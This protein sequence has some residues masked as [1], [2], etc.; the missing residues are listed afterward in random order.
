MNDIAFALL[1][2]GALGTFAPNISAK[3]A[4][5]TPPKASHHC[6]RA[7]QL[8]FSCRISSGITAS[9]CASKDLSRIRGVLTYRIGKPGQV[10]LVYPRTKRHPYQA[11]RLSVFTR[12]YQ[13]KD[14]P[15]SIEILT[16]S[17]KG[18]QL[19][20]KVVHVNNRSE[21]SVPLLKNGRVSALTCKLPVSGNLNKLHELGL[22]E[23]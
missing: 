12:P 3:P 19:A 2:L 7:E 21:A 16:F 20:L 9:L 6:T 4:P 15:T 10:A 8:I 11:F 17:V 14:L 18:Q 23:P 13:G 5:P 22:K 1:S